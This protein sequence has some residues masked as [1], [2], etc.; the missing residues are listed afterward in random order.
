MIAIYTY[1]LF[2]GRE[3]LMPWRTILEVARVM[4]TDG[5]KTV[6]LNACHDEGNNESY[7][8]KGVDILSI[9]TGFDR[10]ADTIMEKGIKTVFIPFT[11]REGLK[12][13]FILNRIPCQ[14]IA[15]LPGGIYDLHSANTLR[16]YSSTVIAKP[17]LLES[18][19]PK[20]FLA[21]AL[22]RCG[23]SHTIGLTSLTAEVARKAKMPNA[24]CVFPGKDSFEE[25]PSDYSLIEKFGLEGKKWLLFSGA[26]APT[27]GAEM[28]LNAMDKA[29]DNSVRLIMLMR[30][31]VDSQ[32]GKF[33]KTISKMRHP[34]R[35]TIIREKASREQLHAFFEMAWYVLLPFIVIPSEIPLTYFEVLSCGTPIVTF[36]NGGTTEYLKSALY[37]SE[38]NAKALAETLDSVWNDNKLHDKKRNAGLALMDNHPD[39]EAVGRAWE[40][41]IE[42]K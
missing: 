41:L 33:E 35:I 26:P 16:K 1:D 11:W 30:T 12:D 21:K 42:Q 38:K 2:P 17:Y 23:F 7:K 19:V 10:L 34:E 40:S 14:K 20:I 22:Q 29:K 9:G 24:C 5:C 18:L 3:F 32:Y 37:I 28:L 13:L 15:Y 36:H 39:W 8:W 4:I 6:I 25:L 27:R 31:D